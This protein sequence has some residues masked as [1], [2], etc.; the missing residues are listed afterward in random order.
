[1]QKKKIE[2]ELSTG[3]KY[4]FFAGSSIGAKESWNDSESDNMFTYDWVERTLVLNPDVKRFVFVLDKPGQFEEF[5]AE[6]IITDTVFALV[7]E[8]VVVIDRDKLRDEHFI[9][10]NRKLW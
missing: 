3:V 1:M 7:K 6:E 8:Y 9:R 4:K 5:V 10:G 2:Y